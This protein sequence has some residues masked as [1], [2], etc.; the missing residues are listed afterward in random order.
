MMNR[1]YGHVG[2]RAKL[3]W[4]GSLRHRYGNG[5]ALGADLGGILTWGLCPLT[6]TAAGRY[7]GRRWCGGPGPIYGAPSTGL[8]SSGSLGAV[9]EPEWMVPLG[10]G[11]PFYPWFR[12]GRGFTEGS[13]FTHLY[14]KRTLLNSQIVLSTY[15]V[16]ERNVHA[17]R[18]VPITIPCSR[19]EDQLAASSTSHESLVRGG[20]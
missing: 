10:Y 17:G 14:R 2:T 15:P 6:T 13:T 18:H 19:P 11:E 20:G 9:S 1:V 12:C 4:A 8:P 3:R 7:I 16:N 5:A